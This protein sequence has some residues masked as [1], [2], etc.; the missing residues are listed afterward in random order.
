M[1]K[2][3][4]LPVREKAILC[5]QKYCR[6]NP[7]LSASLSRDIDA[8]SAYLLLSEVTLMMTWSYTKYLS[9]VPQT[10]LWKMLL[11][12]GKPS[13]GVFD[14]VKRWL[15][16]I[17]IIRLLNKKLL[18]KIQEATEIIL[19]QQQILLKDEVFLTDFLK[20]LRIS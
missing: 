3:A 15:S 18:A 14:Y 5:L 17:S 4:R 10:F 1:D 19:Y 20:K 11:C 16:K 2:I 13:K 7:I 6:I 8:D 9:S 12:I